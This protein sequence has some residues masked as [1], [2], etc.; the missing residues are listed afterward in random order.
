MLPL[1]CDQAVAGLVL[2]EAEDGL[3][4]RLVADEDV[5]DPAVEG[6]EDPPG[7]LATGRDSG[8]G[9][10]GP[11]VVQGDGEHAL[12]HDPADGP[13]GQVVVAAADVPD[14]PGGVE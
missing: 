2:V 10:D 14:G 1:P 13:A 7:L 12:A 8:H 5:D 3:G 6:A 9:R 4:G 11:Q